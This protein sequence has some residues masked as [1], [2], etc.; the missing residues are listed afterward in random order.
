MADKSVI[1]TLIAKDAASGAIKGVD[2]AMGGLKSTGGGLTGILGGL[3]GA[4]TSLPVIIGAGG[5]TAAIIGMT[6]AAADDE[7]AQKRLLAAAQANVPGWNGYSGALDTAIKKSQDLGFTDDEARDSLVRLVT[8]TKDV[9]EATRLNAAAMDLARLKGIPLADAANIIGKVHDG[10]VGILSRYGIEVAKGS[11]ATA[12]LAAI[13]AAASGQ[14]ETYGSTTAGGM[15]RLGIAVGELGEQVGTLF[16]PVMQGVVSLLNDTLLPAISGLI[17]N[18]GGGGT[19]GLGGAFSGLGSFLTPVLDS[20][21]AVAKVVIE[22]VIPTL[23][24]LLTRVWN[25][26]LGSALSMFAELAGR[27][28]STLAQVFSTILSNKDVLNILR[29]AADLLGAALK[30]VAD[31]AKAVFDALGTVFSA[32]TGNKTVMDGLELVVKGIWTGLQQVVGFATDVVTWFGKLFSGIATNK[33]VM[34]IFRGVVD[35]IATGFGPPSTRSPASGTSFSRSGSSS[36]TT[37]SPPSSAASATSS[38][39]RRPAATRARVTRT[40]SASADPSCSSRRYRDASSPA[41]TPAEGR[42]EVRSTSA[43]RSAG[44]PSSTRSAWAPGRSRTC[45]FRRSTPRAPV[46]GATRWRGRRF[47]STSTGTTSQGRRTTSRPT[48]ART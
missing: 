38:A 29:A 19:G 37:P 4:L 46:R 22:Q 14:A 48:R 40:S 24:D 44:R 1:F 11:D 31:F 13:Q 36:R 7:A 9:D 10:N 12:A 17:T 21:K 28:Y 5:V 43:S 30:L 3:G 33:G 8:S 6:K 20:L 35:A 32:I 42:A 47:A 2:R 18:L 23:L 41:S 34:D 39:A 27:V 45:C 16:L 15:D 26:G 25:G